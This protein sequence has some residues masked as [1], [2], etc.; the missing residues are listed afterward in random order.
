MNSVDFDY[1]AF[2]G[3]LES[4][5]TLSTTSPTTTE[6]DLDSGIGNTP[7]MTFGSD[8][9]VIDFDEFGKK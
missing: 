4:V 6:N 2:L 5:D 1:D 3:D 8:N 7:P 9:T